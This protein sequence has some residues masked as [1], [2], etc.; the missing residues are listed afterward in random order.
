MKIYYVA[1]I[2]ALAIPATAMMHRPSAEKIM[3]AAAVEADWAVSPGIDNAIP[4]PW[5]LP[6]EKLKDLFSADRLGGYCGL[7]AE[8]AAQRLR[9]NGYDAFSLNYGIAGGDLTHVTTILHQR[10]KF[11][12]MDPT[13]A[14]TLRHHG[15][16]VDIFDAL[17]GHPYELHQ[18]DISA[19]DW[20]VHANDLESKRARG[21][22]L[23]ECRPIAAIGGIDTLKC[24]IRSYDVRAYA[25]TV[26]APLKKAGLPTDDR[27]LIELMRK[28]LF[29]VGIVKSAG[30][31]ERFLNRWR[32]A[33]LPIHGNP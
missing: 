18:G 28:G 30:T 7:T 20:L 13:F 19:R 27:V 9:Q 26:S 5:T 22:L 31:R 2:G 21:I 12:L 29:G 24:H 23:E 33:G 17:A 3:T 32:A 16:P 6:H 14:A 1:A 11:Y 4:A 8:F 10:G 25:A 15:A